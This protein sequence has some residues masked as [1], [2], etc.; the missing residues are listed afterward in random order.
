LGYFYLKIFT[1]LFEKNGAVEQSDFDGWYEAWKK[2][3]LTFSIVWTQQY[4]EV[5]KQIKKR[6]KI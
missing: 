2:Y 3:G 6:S 5:Y 1:F 4:F